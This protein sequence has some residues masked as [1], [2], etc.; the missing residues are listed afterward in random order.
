MKFIGTQVDLSPIQNGDDGVAARF[1]KGLQSAHHF[2]VEQA[3]LPLHVRDVF[4]HGVQDIN[5]REM[6]GLPDTRLNHPGGV[7]V[8][9]GLLLQEFPIPRSQQQQEQ[10]LT[11]NRVFAINDHR[12]RMT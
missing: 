3:D 5:F 8:L 10:S 4:V 7:Q 2:S 6:F 12:P 11:T 1:R 9:P